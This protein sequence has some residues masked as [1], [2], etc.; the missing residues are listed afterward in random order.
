MKQAIITGASGFVGSHL[1]ER[2]SKSELLTIPHQ[3][4]ATKTLPDFDYFF[5]LSAYGNMASHTDDGAVLQANVV[6]LTRMILEAS[7]HCFKSFVFIST[8]SVKLPVQTMY[9]RTKRAGEEILLSFIEKY[10][11][12]ICIIRPYSITGVGEQKE[13]LIPTL[14]RSCLT[15]ELINFVPY[16]THD[17]IDVEDVVDGL[18]T[19]S[20]ASARGIYEL[21]SGVKYTNQEVREIVEKV[22]GKKANVNIVESV[23]PYDTDNWVSQNYKA[24]GYGWLPRKNL[25]TSI[26]EM[27]KAY[28]TK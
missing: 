19:L 4:I 15:G 10:K 11:L 23:R 3:A 5:F 13:H 28:T 16:P 8:S 14:I 9:S 24:R 18:L 12:P 27:V 25:E 17:F 26:R 21:G 1:K 7:E 22:T 2:F 20:K 6:D